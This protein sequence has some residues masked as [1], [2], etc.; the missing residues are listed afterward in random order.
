MNKPIGLDKKIIFD[1]MTTSSVELSFDFSRRI[2]FISKLS[3]RQKY[4]CYNYLVLDN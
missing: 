1:R 2:F 4:F 3:C